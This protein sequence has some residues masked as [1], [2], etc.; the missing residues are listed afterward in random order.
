[1][2]NNE[3]L[4]IDFHS[5]DLGTQDEEVESVNGGEHD[6]RKIPTLHD[7]GRSDMNVKQI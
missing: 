3:K 7:S 4:E 2:K 6:G 1:M 5:F